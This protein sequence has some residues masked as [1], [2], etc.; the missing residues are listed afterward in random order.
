MILRE[1]RGAVT[2]LALVTCG[3]LVAV[4]VNLGVPG[5][6]LLQSIRFHIA[7]ALLVLVLV[8]LF[9]GTWRRALLFLVVFG[10]SAGEGAYIVFQQQTGR[11]IIGAETAKPLLKLLSF[12]TLQSNTENGQRIADM[13]VASGADVVLLMEAGPVTP[14]FAK[15]LA[16]Y[17]SIAGCDGTQWCETMLL[18]KT[19][20]AAVQVRSLSRVW[21]NR[22]ITATTVIGGQT[23]NL[24]A[25]HLVKPYFDEIADDEVRALA[26]VI[27]GLDG[28]L[29]LAG[30]FNAAGWSDSIDRLARDERL[31]PGP[32]YPATWP[33]RA[34]MFGVP[35]DNIWTRAPLLIEQVAA[36]PDAMGSNHRGLT[37]SLSIAGGQ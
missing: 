15:L 37:A 30:D 28:P 9:T 22:L 31:I 19:P 12:N 32:A 20:L 6:A 8:L 18:S 11:E 34:G 2:A 33:V 14:Y 16:A 3:V 5:Q 4:S 27:H 17:P 25:A 24:V 1:L 29:V 10:A 26:E 7:A 35:I 36:L 21:S 23:I 13:V